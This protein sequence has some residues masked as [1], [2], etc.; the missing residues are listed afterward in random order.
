MLSRVTD[1]PVVYYSMK[2]IIYFVIFWMLICYFFNF[3]RVS[4]VYFLRGMFTG[5]F[6][7]SL[8]FQYKDKDTG[9]LQKQKRS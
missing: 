5:Y 2:S 8:H 4:P 6:L 9:N 7:N 1:F 3:L